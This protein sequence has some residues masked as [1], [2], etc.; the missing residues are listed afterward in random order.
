MNPVIENIL[1]D[2]GFNEE[3]LAVLEPLGRCLVDDLTDMMADIC[4]LLPPAL[5]VTAMV[6]LSRV[7]E[8]RMISIYGPFKNN[9]RPEA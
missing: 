2:A 9:D 5:R 6:Y 4:A 7:V 1:H 8:Q 3:H